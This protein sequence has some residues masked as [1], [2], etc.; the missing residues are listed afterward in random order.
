MFY[1]VI[2]L[3]SVRVHWKKIRENELNP[4]NYKKN[5]FI[6]AWI[7]GQWTIKCFSIIYLNH[8]RSISW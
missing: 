1:Q 6:T 2:P 7:Y 8:I 3:I 5:S 4:R